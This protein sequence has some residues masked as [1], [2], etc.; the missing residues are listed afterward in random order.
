MYSKDYQTY[1]ESE[2]S[3]KDIPNN[4]KIIT[5]SPQVVE[6]QIGSKSVINFT[7][8]NY[9]GF[10]NNQYFLKSIWKIESSYQV[11]KTNIYRSLE[12]KISDFLGMED[13]IAYASI[14]DANGGV[15]DPL[16]TQD[17]A[18]IFDEQNH[19]SDTIP[20]LGKSTC[21]HYKSKSLRD[22]E[23]QLKKASSHNYRFK[24]IVTEGVFFMDGIM[25]DLKGICDLAEKYN[26]LVFVNDSEATGFIGKTGRGTHE[27]HG[28]MERVDII[29]STFGKTFGWFTS[30][31]KEIIN[32]LRER[33]KPYIFSN[34][35]STAVADTSIQIIDMLSKDNLLSEKVM[36]NTVYFCKK[37]KEAGFDIIEGN[38]AIVSVMLYDSKLAQEFANELFYEGIYVTGFFHPVVPKGKARIRIQLSAAHT[39]EHLDKAVFS[40]SKVGKEL[41]VI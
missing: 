17:D 20:S 39:I 4:K 37:I 15:L 16:F 5:P 6:L 8:S 23:N 34:S 40:F 12:K 29:T 19:I 21:Y 28:V 27:Y 24:I 25:A 7:S 31:R 14:Y 22:L 18:V 10:S 38:S 13:S 9:L 33:S 2:P 36:Q 1:L 11:H 32:L 3:E 30:G 41:G 35:L 26:A